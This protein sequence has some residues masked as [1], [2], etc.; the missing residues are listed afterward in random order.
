MSIHTHLWNVRKADST[1]SARKASGVKKTDNYE[2]P[3]LHNIY[4]ITDRSM[5]CTVPTLPRSL[6]APRMKRSNSAPLTCDI[7]SECTQGLIQRIHEIIPDPAR[8]R[9][10]AESNRSVCS[11]VLPVC[12]HRSVQYPLG[13][14][15]SATNQTISAAE[16]LSNWATQYVLLLIRNQTKNMNPNA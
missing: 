3:S 8:D 7:E 2:Y 5:R 15:T 10:R 14:P 9:C 1:P 13:I 12:Q 4:I 16:L 6:P 11:R